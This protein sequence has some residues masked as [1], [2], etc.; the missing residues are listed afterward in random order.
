VQAFGKSTLFDNLTE[1]MAM[2]VIQCQRLVTPE[3]EGRYQGGGNDLPI[4]E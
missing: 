3:I 2:H 1:N 4:S